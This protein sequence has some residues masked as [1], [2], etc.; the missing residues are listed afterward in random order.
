MQVS[1]AEAEPFNDVNNGI[2]GEEE[3]FVELL[4][5]NLGGERDKWE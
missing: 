3:G 2:E 1:I 5:A 4:V